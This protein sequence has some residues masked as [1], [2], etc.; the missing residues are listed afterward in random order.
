M[1]ISQR[2]I[3]DA[4]YLLQ[5]QP[6]AENFT[7][8]LAISNSQCKQNLDFQFIAAKAKV[9][10]RIADSTT[11]DFLSNYFET[12]GLIY[13]AICCAEA[14]LLTEEK[15]EVVSK[16]TQLQ[17]KYNDGKE[18]ELVLIRETFTKNPPEITVSV[19]MPTYNRHQYIGQAIV[20]VLNQTFKD[21]ELIIV[22]DGGSREC[23]AV[24]ESFQSDKIRYLYVEHGGLSNAL[25][26]GILISRSKYI[27]YLDDDDR[28]FPDHLQTLVSALE[29]SSY[30]F[31]YTDGYRVVKQHKY[32]QWNQTSKA[33]DYSSDYNP[34]RLAEGN[35]IPILCMAH[36]RDCLEHIG[37][38][39]TDLPNVMDWNLW[40][41]AAKLYEFAHLKKVTCQFEYRIEPDSL[42]GRQL[43]HL[44]FS[45]I[46][47]KHHQYQVRQ[48]WS[49][50]SKR[51][52]S[53]LIGYAE[54]ESKICRYS[55]DKCQL[56]EWLLP[57][58]FAE[59]KWHRAYTL[60]T[61]MTRTQH[62]KALFTIR[63]IIP[64]I[65][66]LAHF[67]LLLIIFLILT[68]VVVKHL[69]RKG[70]NMFRLEHMYGK[71]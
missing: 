40:A 44:F 59:G 18:K 43:D 55:D 41:K 8:F 58:A 60:I 52:E 10:L 45:I 50:L 46:L 17:A 64:K 16:H 36:R 31:V 22:N 53:G 54:I 6:T 35:Y 67:F 63:N 25:N 24:I 13:P 61:Q 42:S 33:V 23:E 20:S 68:E 21:F 12:Q 3:A 65:S 70:L 69:V 26:Q 4:I 5:V 11:L 7:K 57:Y 28:Y 9:V 71:K 39:E 2:E 1:S 66:V 34:G 51:A 14:L 47:C 38:F 27:A 56:A 15:T 30:P 48:V 32:G 37:L 19:I 29:S 62:R 49:S